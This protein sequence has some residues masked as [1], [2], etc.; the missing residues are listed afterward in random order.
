MRG[1]LFPKPEQT[2]RT[3]GTTDKQGQNDPS[4]PT[5]ARIKTIDF[6]SIGTQVAIRADDSARIDLMGAVHASHG[7]PTFKVG[8]VEKRRL[9]RVF[10]PVREAGASVSLSCS[11]DRFRNRQ[12]QGEYS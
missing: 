6:D 4:E 5:T 8:L 12:G 11:A 3:A 7:I 1:V 10:L 2:G 9:L